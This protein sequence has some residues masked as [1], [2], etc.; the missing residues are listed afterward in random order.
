MLKKSETFPS[1]QSLMNNNHL[2]LTQLLWIKRLSNESNA[3]AE[4]IVQDAFPL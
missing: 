3:F 2:K 4:D 1:S